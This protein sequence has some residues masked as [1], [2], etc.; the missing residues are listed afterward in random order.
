MT[1]ELIVAESPY[2]SEAWRYIENGLPAIPVGPGTKVP[3]NFSFGDWRAMHGWQNYA[4]RMPTETEVSIWSDWPRGGVCVPMG[5]VSGLLAIDIDTNRPEII[6]ALEREL[7]GLLGCRKRGSR[8]YAAFVRIPTNS[9]GKSGASNFQLTQTKWNV[10]GM[11]VLDLLGYGRQVVMPPTIHPDTNKPYEWIGELRPW[12][13]DMLPACPDD[14]VERC[15]RAIAPFQSADDARAQMESLE[16]A[17]H[18]VNTSDEEGRQINDAALNQMAKWVPE[19]IKPEYLQSHFNGYRAKPFWRGVVDSFKCSIFTTGIKDFA[20]DKG[21]TPI[22]LVMAVEGVNVHTAMDWLAG[23]LGIERKRSLSAAELLDHLQAGDY[24]RVFARE[25]KAVNAAISAI[26]TPLRPIAKPTLLET[27]GMPPELLT[28]PGILTDVLHWILASSRKPLAEM[29]MQ[30]T[31]AFGSA[32]MAQLYAGPTGLRTNLQLIGVARS[33]FGKG[34]PQLCLKRLLKQTGLESTL[35]GSSIASGSA[36]LAHLAQTSGHAVY[37]LDEVDSLLKTALG[38]NVQA[39]AAEIATYIQ[40]LYSS[41][42]DG[43]FKGKDYANTKEKPNAFIAYPSLTLVGFTT[44]DKFYDTIKGK[45]VASGFLNR[46]LILQAPEKRPAENQNPA[47]AAVIPPGVQEWVN[48]LRRPDYAVIGK[49]GFGATP[50]NP[51]QVAYVDDGA[52]RVL[53][54]FAVEME[55]RMDKMHAAANGLDDALVRCSENAHKV[56]LI[57]AGAKHPDRPR[58]DLECAEFAVKYVR[59]CANLTLGAIETR[60]VES[61]FDD[62]VQKVHAFLLRCGERGAGKADLA[63]SCRAYRALDERA[64]NGVFERLCTAGTVDVRLGKRG[65]QRWFAVEAVDNLDEFTEG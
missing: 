21:Y 56:A 51:V 33:G 43:S 45:D 60:V 42:D 9:D 44:P 36:L 30:V 20:E 62:S 29:A 16:R 11:R 32:V 59:H 49:T 15:R 41:S 48:S 54:A 58:I 17:A 26:I 27:Q 57:C 23:K 47:S 63:R 6:A 64:A 10:D 4:N 8:G 1:Q 38:A 2:A 22:D 40:Q 7:A 37:V 55:E 34:H 28:P 24:F 18:Q 31:L 52:E 65:G 50:D 53:L 14:L 61:E 46:M 39:H 19:L 3:G 12:D 35:G 13:K 25:D 5:G